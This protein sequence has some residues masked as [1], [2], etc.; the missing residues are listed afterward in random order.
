[1][2]DGAGSA[3]ICMN[4]NILI[5]TNVLVYAYDLSEVL[6]QE[7]SLEL[8][9][10]LT[11]LGIGSISTQVIGELFVALTRKLT[12]P[13]SVED[14]LKRV[15]QH[16]Q[17]WRLLDVTAFVVLEAIRGVRRH[18]LNYLDAQIWAT[19]RMHGIPLIFS[20]DFSDGTLLEGVRFVNP[21]SGH[22][23]MSDWI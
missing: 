5:D 23:K 8:L 4:G 18:R 11:S 17:I 6:K 20:E 2:A 3:T 19:A 14:G 21:L 22:F 12:I 15:E 10:E 16:L 13:L 1:V 9:T 7:R